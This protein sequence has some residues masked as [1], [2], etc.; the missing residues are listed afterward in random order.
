MHADSIDIGDFTCQYLQVA[1]LQHRDK[2]VTDIGRCTGGAQS[3]HKLRMLCPQVHY[4]KLEELPVAFHLFA[5]VVLAVLFAVA[6]HGRHV[7]A[8]DAVAAHP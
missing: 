4:L 5:Q 1:L 7:K 2:P 8:G 3:R 6:R